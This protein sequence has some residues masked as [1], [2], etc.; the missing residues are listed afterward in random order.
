MNTNVIERVCVSGDER[1]EVEKE[2]KKGKKQKRKRKR[3]EKEKSME[4]VQRWLEVGGGREEGIR[5]RK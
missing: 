2:K 5:R 1:R 3:R 4:T